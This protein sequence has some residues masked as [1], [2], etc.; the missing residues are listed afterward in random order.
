MLQPYLKSRKQISNMAVHPKKTRLDHSSRTTFTDARGFVAVDPTN[1]LIV[2]AFRG[3]ETFSNLLTNLASLFT[4]NSTACTSC[5]VAVGFNASWTEASQ[6]VLPAIDQAIKENAGF[7]VL[8]TG[9]SLGG[10]I[11]HFAAYQLRT[12][13]PGLKVD[14]VSYIDR[15]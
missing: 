3:T 4:V 11:A 7:K 13:N 6:T 5:E 2:L 9:H 1:Q 14:L 8:A 12:A 15:V 10:A